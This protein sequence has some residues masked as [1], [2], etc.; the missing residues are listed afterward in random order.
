MNIHLKIDGMHCS[1]CVGAVRRVLAAVPSVSAVSVDLGA[2]RATI[3][4][5]PDI[6]PDRLIAAVQGAGYAARIES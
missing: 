2:G 5:S 3:E 4:A 6:D 1:G